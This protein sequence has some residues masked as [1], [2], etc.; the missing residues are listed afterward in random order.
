[1]VS[2]DPLGP[3]RA[4]L[5]ARV[6]GWAGLDLAGIRAD[7]AAFMA[8]AGPAG[9]ALADPRPAEV[10]G[11]PAAWLGAAEAPPALYLHGGGFQIGGLAS[12]AGLAARLAAAAGLRLLVPDYRLAPGHRWPAA[13]DDA[14]AVYRA[15][16]AAGEAPVA[17]LGD[18]AG[19]ALALRVA[20]R[21]RDAGLAQARALA[22]ISPWLDLALS[23]Q[24][25]AR[26]AGADPFSRP[27]QLAAMARSYLGRDGPAPG[28]ARVSPVHGDL[29][30]LPPILVHAGAC[31]ITLDDAHLLRARAA[32]AG[33]RVD[34]TVFPGMCHHFQMFEALPQADASVAAIGAWLRARTRNR[35][36]S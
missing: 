13:E 27:A 33:G 15:M 32:A 6:A 19:G 16:A 23:G 22:L 3:I 36:A 4:T 30:D 9:F 12:H 14:F 26:L 31:D 25:Y 35:A 2:A 8:Q 11:V 34:L 28:D 17:V 24:S 1:M 18:S 20:M 5:Q 7:F 29:A 10:A 21:V